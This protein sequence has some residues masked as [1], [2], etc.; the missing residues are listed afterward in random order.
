MRKFKVSL[1]LRRLMAELRLGWIGPFKGEIGIH[2]ALFGKR[3]SSRP[4]IL[5]IV[6]RVG[7]VWV[8]TKVRK[9]VLFPAI[10]PIELSLCA[11][12]GSNWERKH[13]TV[14]LY[15]SLVIVRFE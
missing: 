9:T 13:W 6:G 8:S 1:A 5:A 3:I 7:S 2:V 10:R 14:C 4:D 12:A 11:V 15:S